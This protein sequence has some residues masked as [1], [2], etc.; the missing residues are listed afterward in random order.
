MLNISFF[1]YKG[2]SG[3]TSLM[4]NT[5]PFLAQELKATN[6]EPLIVI[7]LDIDSKGMSFLVN[8]NSNINAIQ[9]LKGDSAIC[10]R[11]RD[12]AIEEHPFFKSLVPIGS[13]VG[14]DRSLNR[15]I[16]FVSANSTSEDNKFLDGTNNFDPSNASLDQLNIL[17]NYFKCKAI[18]MD[19]PA[20]GQL[21]G[22]LALRITNKIVTVMRITKQFRKGTY[23]FLK[24][25][26]SRCNNKEFVLVPNAVPNCEGTIYSVDTIMSEIQ[27]AA[28]D[29]VKNNKLNLKMIADNS[30][31]VNEV[32]QFKFEEKNLFAEAGA[33][34][35]ADDEK[36]A[37]DK[38]KKLAKELTKDAQ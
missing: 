21:A 33:R 32:R 26:S 24:E 10:F 30:N 34:E 31:G 1:S 12:V 8:D 7:D 36:M 28:N 23:E 27:R 3:R 29:S 38:Y 15:S 13:L 4:F 37:L 18:V 20:G 22:E 25:K 14:L 11:K 35:L 6:H 19:T 16:L 17:C 5:L 9:V 2:G